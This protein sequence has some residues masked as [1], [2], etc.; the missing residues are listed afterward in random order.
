MRR[1]DDHRAGC[2]GWYTGLEVAERPA[3]DEEVPDA[4]PPGE[5]LVELFAG[6]QV[7]ARDYYF[8]DRFSAGQPHSR[9]CGEGDVQIHVSSLWVPRPGTIASSFSCG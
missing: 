6:G 1:G 9:T 2:Q 8:L 3:V 7:R 4:E 5:L